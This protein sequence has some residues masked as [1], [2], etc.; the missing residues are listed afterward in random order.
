M[1]KI[2]VLIADDHQLMR[3]GLRVL[4]ERDG[5]FQV[6]AEAAGQRLNPT[7]HATKKRTVLSPP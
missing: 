5:E 2:R 3:S 4:L 7:K 6:V 1:T